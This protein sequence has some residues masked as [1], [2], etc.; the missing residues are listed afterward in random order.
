LNASG[1]D[2]ARHRA[3]DRWVDAHRA[4][5]VEFLREVVRIPTDM[6]PGDNAPAA[7]R[8][9]DLLTR[10]GFAVERHPVPAALLEP[11]GMKSLVN[12]VV[13][14][15]FGSGGPTV[16]LN[17][18][19][20]VVPPGDGWSRPP[21][22]GVVE[23]GRMYGRGVAVSKSDV[24]TYAFALAAL[25]DAGGPLRGAIELHFTY[26]EEFGG[27]LGP[28]WL[29]ARHIVRPDLAIAAG[30]SYAVVT[31]HSGCLQLEV[32][33][34]GRSSHG[35]MPEAGRD[36]LQAAV[37][38]LNALYAQLP[39]LKSIRSEVA[40]IEHPTMVVGLVSGGIN[41][42]V[43]PDRVTFRLDRRMIPEEDAQ[44]VDADLCAAIAAAVA[45]RDGIRVEIRRLLLARPLEPL[46]GHERLVEPLRRHAQRVFGESIPAAG[47]ALYTDA[48]H[49]GEAGIPVV[50][51]GAG[52]RT[53]LEAH[54]KRPD[55]NLLLD[56]LHRATKV[57]AGAVSDLLRP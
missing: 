32:T 11:Y 52:P 21:Y 51:Y 39:G 15:R 25:R 35:S 40:G 50:L 33:V 1:T 16:A 46:A 45:E 48:R 56:D 30:F 49:Y 57:V 20:D 28:A 22:G 41:T 6:P 5:Q 27:L 10:L 2:E 24:A 37:A 55:E 18:H 47:V 26:D 23:D 17:A 43:V 53:L 4:G 8:T 19:G 3:T 38:I 54:A 42:N 29:L 31:A 36:A 12:L 13:R 34:H 14:H 7:E 44:Q 9:A